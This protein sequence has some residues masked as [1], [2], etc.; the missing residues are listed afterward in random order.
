[1]SQWA[2][3]SVSLIF[4]LHTSQKKTILEFEETHI[5]ADKNL[6]MK[7]VTVV[8]VSGWPA[9]RIYVFTCGLGI[10]GTKNS[11]NMI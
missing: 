4:V 11:S 2:G 5:N 6:L 1:M 10:D 3:L 8:S 9:M 7:I